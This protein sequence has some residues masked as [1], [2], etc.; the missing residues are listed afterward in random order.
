M[1]F[2]TDS[3]TAYG[4]VY[5]A[6]SDGTGFVDQAACPNSTKWH[7]WFAIQP[8]EQVR[9]GDLDGDG[10]DDFFTFLPPPLAQC[11]TVLSQGTAMGAERAVAG[12]GGAGRDGPAVRGR[13]RTATARRT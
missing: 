8:D 11:Y 12:D 10:K 7:D 4:D 5:V 2:A 1:T 3:P 9:I 6:L 13:R